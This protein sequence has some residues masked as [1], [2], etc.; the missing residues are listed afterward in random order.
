MQTVHVNLGERSYDILIGG[1]LVPTF[2]GHVGAAGFGGSPTIVISD[3]NVAPLYAEKVLAQLQ[4]LGCKAELATV[5]AGEPSKCSERL[6]E[7][8]GRAIDAGLDRNSFVVALGGGVV[9]DLAGFVAGSFLRG[10]RFV[11]VPTSLLSMVDSAVGGKTGIN[12]PQGK[13]LIGAFHQP[14]LVLADLDVLQTLPVREFAAG[15]AEVIKYG[16]IYDADLFAFLE[17]NVDAIKSLDRAAMTHLVQRS[18]EIKAEVVEQDERE[19]GLRAILNYGHTLGHAIEKVTEYKRFLHGE[20]IAIGMV[21]ASIL[22]EEICGLPQAASDRQAELFRAFDLPVSCAD[23]DWDGLREAM[24]VDKK[25]ANSI[26]K[27]VLAESVG[28]VNLPVAVPEAALKNAWT[29][30]NQRA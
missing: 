4:E 29:A 26:P 10:V 12:L 17:S 23:L 19:G 25:A 21:Y 9:G 24:S 14:S 22:S 18:C 16:V 15:M 13:N 27:Y 2:G 8:W 11:Q 1:N 20:A 5:P 28:K 30:L 6:V 7:L 3:S